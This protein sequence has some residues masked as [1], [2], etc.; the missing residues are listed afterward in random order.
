MG[1]NPSRDK[2]W[3]NYP[4]ENVSWEDC[5]RFIERLNNR[6]GLDFRLPMEAE[7]EYA[8]RGGV[9]SKG[10]KYAGSDGLDEV[11]WYRDNSGGHTHPVGKKKPNELGL[12]DMSGNVWEW[13]QNWFGAYSMEAQTNPT[14]PQSGGDRVLR[15]GG[16]WG[17]ARFC[18]VSDRFNY[19]PG[20]R[21]NSSGLR[22][23]LAP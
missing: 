17:D 15:G 12:H 1:E 8:A 3:D 7:W 20:N 11:G 5:Q 6:T 10:Y 19:V 22:L 21:G 18:R 2:A 13:C 4:V 16:Y 9:K 14:G 23:V